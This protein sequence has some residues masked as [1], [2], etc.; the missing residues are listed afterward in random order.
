MNRNS[1][2]PSATP[3]MTSPL[4]TPMT[5][6]GGSRS[7]GFVRFVFSNEPAARLRGLRGRV[8][9]A[10]GLALYDQGLRYLVELQARDGYHAPKLLEVLD[11]IATERRRL[12]SGVR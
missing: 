5:G 12:R 3:R 2:T 9:A 8:E 10:L 7:D 1:P 6:W 11:Q 4:A